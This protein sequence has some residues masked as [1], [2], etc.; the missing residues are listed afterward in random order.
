MSEIGNIFYRSNIYERNK[1]RIKFSLDDRLEGELVM[2]KKIGKGGFKVFYEIENTNYVL[3][4]LLERSDDAKIIKKHLEDELDGFEIQHILSEGSTLDYGIPKIYEY[5]KMKQKFE[6]GLEFLDV[7]FNYVIMEKGGENLGVFLTKEINNYKRGIIKSKFYGTINVKTQEN[8]NTDK[9][10][11]DI[12]FHRKK[13]FYN[14]L[15]CIELIHNKGYIHTDIKIDQFLIHEENSE[16]VRIIDFGFLNKIGKTFTEA[17]GTHGYIAPHFKNVIDKK[18]V[19]ATQCIDIYSLGVSFLNILY[20]SPI[21]L[22]VNKS[23]NQKWGCGKNINMIETV[24]KKIL[25]QKKISFTKEEEE[26]LFPMIKKMLMTP[27]DII[28]SGRITR[29]IKK[30][31][32]CKSEFFGEHCCRYESIKEILDEPYFNDE[33]FNHYIK[34]ERE[35]DTS[36]EVSRE[37]TSLDRKKILKLWQKP[38]KIISTLRKLKSHKKSPNN[39]NNNSQNNRNSFN[40]IIRKTRTKIVITSRPPSKAS[41]PSKHKPSNNPSELKKT[42]RRSSKRK[43]KRKS[44]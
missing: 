41:K 7:N 1:K 19:K 6:E 35:S 43:S 22:E 38:V 12:A 8:N 21:C 20:G 27:I 33:K 17:K 39:S 25:A 15:K 24:V 40:K 5:G 16:R 26:T 30:P 11:K 28:K 44:F 14:M 32:N 42:S 36:Q 37:M 23:I 10:K 9:E 13:F 3:G 4:L 2:K 18:E 29:E 31:S 34:N